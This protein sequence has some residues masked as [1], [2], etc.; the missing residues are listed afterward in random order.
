MNTTW[1]D[2]TRLHFPDR[3]AATAAVGAP[4]TMPRLH[5]QARKMLDRKLA[6]GFTLVEGSVRTDTRV[7]EMLEST[8]P[9]VHPV[10]SAYIEVVTYADLEA[11]RC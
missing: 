9:L 8:W 3:A 11:P 4:E 10:G 6:E 5:A 2:M 1:H 7:V